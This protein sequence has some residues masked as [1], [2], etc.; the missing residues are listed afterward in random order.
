MPDL[1]TIIQITYPDD[2]VSVICDKCYIVH[3]YV[4]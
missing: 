1:K 4:I 3:L 2:G